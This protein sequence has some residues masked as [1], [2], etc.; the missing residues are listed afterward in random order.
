MQQDNSQGGGVGE[1]TLGEA[2]A[3]N[4]DAFAG[5]REPSGGEADDT[6]FS[7]E[8]PLASPGEL[9]G[10]ADQAIAREI[11]ALGPADGTL[12]DTADEQG[13]PGGDSRE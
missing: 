9:A 13:S 5:S 6:D 7:D 12:A 2:N 11:E 8:H 4:E 10:P 3:E 1:K